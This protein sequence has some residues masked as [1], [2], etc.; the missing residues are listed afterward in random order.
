MQKDALEECSLERI[1]FPSEEGSGLMQ[2]AL[3]L[4]T[5]ECSVSRHFRNMKYAVQH[6]EVSEILSSLETGEKG[7][8]WC[9]RK[10]E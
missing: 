5:E 6:I 2:V 7:S 10:R 9:G 3:Y 4:F 8:F 1:C